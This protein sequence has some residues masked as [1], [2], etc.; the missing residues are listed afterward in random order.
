MRGWSTCSYIPQS[1]DSEFHI[2]VL[3]C[4]YYTDNKKWLPNISRHAVRC[5]QEANIL[6]CSIT[7]CCSISSFKCLGMLKPLKK[8][9]SIPYF[10]S[11]LGRIGGSGEIP[12]DLMG[13]LEAFSLALYGY[14]WTTS[15]NG[16]HYIKL[17]H[18]WVKATSTLEASKS[19][20]FTILPPCH[21]WLSYRS[22]M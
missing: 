21:R 10:V 22:N 14:P 19:I 20:Y 12:D 17:I 18:L 13:K 6:C 11:I 5:T 7:D 3:C 9:Q 8:L 4:H 16:L 15:V 1:I 2:T